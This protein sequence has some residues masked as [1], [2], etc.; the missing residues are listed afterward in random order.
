MAWVIRCPLFKISREN[1][2]ILKTNIEHRLAKVLSNS[3][4][5]QT[6]IDLKNSLLNG[7][8]LQHSFVLIQKNQKIK[9][10]K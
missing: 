6:E 7:L 9:A 1:V 10:V 5:N 3:S 2:R 4:R 8:N